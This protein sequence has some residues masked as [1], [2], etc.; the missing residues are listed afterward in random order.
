MPRRIID[1]S[2]AL[3]NDIPADPPIMR[4]AI[5]YTDHHEGFAAFAQLL[6]GLKKEDL[7]DGEAGAIE[8]VELTTHNGTHLDAPYHFHST[9]N[10]SERA[11][12][13]DQVDLN[14]CFQPGIKLDFRHFPD[15]YV[16]SAADVE[17]EL[18]R[19]GHKLKS[20]EIVLVNTRAG[21]RY[22]RPDYLDS[23]CGM[24]Y[25]ATMYLLERSVRLTGTDGWSWDAPFSY[26]VKRYMATGIAKLFGKDTK[27]AGISA[28]AT[29]R[30]C[31]TWR[32]CLRIISSLC[33]FR[34]KYEVRR[35]GGPGL[36]QFWTMRY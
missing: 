35:P 3:E 12:T 33:V 24:G 30:N 22:G 17:Q 23:G 25:E 9:M 32:R 28:I 2:V 26:T 14:W 29:W 13:I 1:I 7:P 31:T 4:P 18:T 36:S 34:R 11:A 19:I 8:S 27:P 10:R 15:G 20:L 5:R 21:A 6:P 16:A